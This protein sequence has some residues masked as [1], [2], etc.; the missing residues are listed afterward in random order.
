MGT[1]HAG[2]DLA[3]WAALFTKFTN[4]LRPTNH[5]IVEVLTPDSEVLAG[6]QKDFHTMLRAR[7]PEINIMCFYEELPVAGVGLVSYSCP[8]NE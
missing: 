1:P 7:K 6:I 8:A 3:N 5:R 4:L 2:A